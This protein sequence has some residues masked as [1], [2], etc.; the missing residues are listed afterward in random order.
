MNKATVTSKG[1]VTLPKEIRER[2]G[3]ERGDKLLFELHGQDVVMRVLHARSVDN[4]FE[5][6]AG[7]ADFQGEE[8]EAEAVRA[9]AIRKHRP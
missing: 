8:A 3:I 6:F 1:Q 9:A 5:Q 2:L 4:L 7:A